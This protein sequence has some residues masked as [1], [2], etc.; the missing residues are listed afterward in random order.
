MLAVSS[1]RRQIA[2]RSP[3]HQLE[4]LGHDARAALSLMQI[5]EFED[6]RSHRLVAG[7]GKPIEQLPLDRRQPRIVGRQ[8]VARAAHQAHR[9][10]GDRAR[11]TLSSISGRGTH[12]P[13]PSCLRICSA[14]STESSSTDHAS[15][16]SSWRLERLRRLKTCLAC[17]SGPTITASL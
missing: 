3:S 5:G 1:G 8:P 16:L 17:S 4:E 15:P 11:S 2:G 6:R 14:L 7:P 13:A 10:L 12:E 9:P